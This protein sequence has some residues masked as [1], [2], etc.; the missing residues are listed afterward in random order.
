MKEYKLI[1]AKLGYEKD[2]TKT[3]TNASTSINSSIKEFFFPNEFANGI[4]H[5][6]EVE[7]LMQEMN[8]QGWEVS[9]VTPLSPYPPDIVLLITFEREM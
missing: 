1:T 5:A 4:L 6:E 3:K 8:Q 2:K 9:A 7:T